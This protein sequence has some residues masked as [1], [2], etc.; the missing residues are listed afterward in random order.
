[1]FLDTSG[2]LCFHH[3]AEPQHADAVQLFKS[4][5]LRLTHSYVLAE[6]VALAQARGLPRQAALSFIADLQDNTAQ[7]R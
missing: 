4:A 6:F 5:V 3:R 2:L 7:F 1:M